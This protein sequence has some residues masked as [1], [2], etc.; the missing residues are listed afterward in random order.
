M[1]DVKQGYEQADFW[2]WLQVHNILPVIIA[3]S[4]VIG[5]YYILVSKQTVAEL[6]IADL[7][8]QVS[9]LT[10]R[11]YNNTIVITQLSTKLGISIPEIKL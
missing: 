9:Y 3:I 7:R 11:D 8:Q 2:T 1:T 5:A 4:S 10:N 6:Q